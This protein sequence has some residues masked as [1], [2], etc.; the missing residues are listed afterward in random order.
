MGEKMVT[1]F[2]KKIVNKSVNKS[3]EKNMVKNLC[4]NW[5]KKLK[6]KISGSKRSCSGYKVGCDAISLKPCPRTHG[7]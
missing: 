4:T 5:W 3:I 2:V 6:G 1:K 7:M